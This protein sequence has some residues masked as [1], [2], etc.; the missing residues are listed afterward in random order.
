VTVGPVSGPA[1]VM[2]LAF[3]ARGPIGLA[4]A[5]MGTPLSKTVGPMPFIVAIGGMCLFVAAG[6]RSRTP[7]GRIYVTQTLLGDE[8][9][10][11]P[12]RVYARR[13]RIAGRPRLSA[14][15]MRE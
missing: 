13:I 10:N 5:V 11:A 7:Y 4:A 1:T 2:T 8:C 15:I 6:S 14:L 3:A 9:L 12:E